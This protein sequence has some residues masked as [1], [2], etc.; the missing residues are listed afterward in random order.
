MTRRLYLFG[1]CSLDV[2]ARELRRGGQRIDLSPTLFDA[3]AYLVEHRARAVG[4]DELVAA[5]WGKTAVSDTVVGKAIL[6][7]RRAI[8]DTAEAQAFLRTVPRF[9]YHWVADTRVVEDD[10]TTGPTEATPGAAP[11]RRA[12]PASTIPPTIP[13]PASGSVHRVRAVIAALLVMLL[14]SGLAYTAWLS[15]AP[16]AREAAEPTGFDDTGSAAV[17]VL[18]VDVLAEPSDAWLRLGLMD[19]VATR[20]REAG[21]VVVSSDTVVRLVADA[22]DG[23]AARST[24][25]H[26]LAPRETVALA[27]RRSASGWVVRVA[28]VDADG[29]RR[30]TQAEADDALAAARTASDQVLALLG[31]GAAMPVTAGAAGLEELL[32][33]TDAARL[34]ENLELARSIID[35]APPVLRALPEVRM[36]AIRIDLRKGEFSRAREATEALLRDVTAEADPVTHARLLE[37]LC[38]ARMRLGDLED[39]VGLCSRSIDLLDSRDQP[40]ALGR[41][42]NNR[43]V[44][45]THLQ[46]YE[47]AMADFARSRVAI[48]LAGDP[49]LMA[50][51]DGNESAVEMARGR[52]AEALQPLER[53]AARFGRFGMI[54]EQAT[55]VFNQIDARMMLVEPQAALAASDAGW[56]LRDRIT[57]P[58]LRQ[59][60]ALQRAD[61]LHA[62]GRLAEARVLL[63]ELVAE[64]LPVPRALARAALARLDLAGDQPRLAIVLTGQAMAEPALDREERARARAWLTLTRALRR[65]DR[66]DDAAREVHALATWADTRS[67][68]IILLQARLAEAEQAAADHDEASFRR[69]CDAALATATRRG[70]ADGVRDAAE[71]CGGLLIAHG[72]L[73]GAAVVVGRVAPFAD[74][75]FTS[76]VLEARL[77]HALGHVEAW[78][79][80]LARV[81][82]LAGERRIPE[83]LEQS[84]MTPAR[85]GNGAAS[86]FASIRND[87]GTGR[88]QLRHGAGGAD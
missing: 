22:K 33:R 55:T 5:V 50:Q 24:L 69:A 87:S 76:A 48:R 34:S 3:I 54:N 6:G 60:L 73:A 4:R 18:P 49:L 30:E 19:L 39:A 45:Y 42:Y 35:E 11:S 65:D 64:A 83:G 53:I 88:E 13:S 67:A 81:R 63:D 51:I 36:R 74:R 31:R 84:P 38:V 7:A 29:R 75:D 47:E 77:S 23:E 14:I 66:R 2:A 25:Q 58:F 85:I 43:G 71:S 8:G 68:D 27:A 9:G 32:R 78:R 40:E 86:P 56:T 16:S 79:S 59:M 10:D 61:V 46:R 17:A 26:A 62:N 72:D 28:L 70:T 1:D 21:L 12:E 41:A 15:R 20:L 37:N 57:E 44:A 52:P 80:A 82:Q